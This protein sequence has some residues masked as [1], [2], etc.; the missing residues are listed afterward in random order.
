[1]FILWQITKGGQ[2]MLKDQQGRCWY[3]K[4]G[5][6][7]SDKLCDLLT[8][9]D[10][11]IVIYD[12]ETTGTTKDS[13]VV[14]FA[15][16][17]CEP[18]NGRY[19]I[20]K[21]MNQL[22]KPPIPM[23]AEASAVNHITDDM[24]K[25]APAEDFVVDKIDEIFKG[26]IV[27]GY[28]HVSFDNKML[29]NMY[30]R[31]RGIEFEPF[32]DISRNVDALIIA[33]SLVDRHEAPEQRFTLGSITDL[34]GIKPDDNEVLHDALADT[35][36]TMKLIWALARDYAGSEE[37][38]EYRDQKNRPP[39]S[40]VKMTRLTYSKIADYVV[41]NVNC[42]GMTGQFRYEIY[43]KRFVEING[44]IMSVGN[45]EQFIIDA[46]IAAGGNITKIKQE[47]KKK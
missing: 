42:Q 43:D 47:G 12:T 14:Q 31:T 18:V 29:N 7:M 34:Y 30:L 4:S 2:K 46:D 45:M 37:M 27:A 35:K 24:L 41:V 11:P 26:A 15:G 3:P 6:S 40:I 21:Q 32:K 20:T 38:N 10:T 16:I 25:D 8:R 1:M 28:N 36:V 39:I 5:Y 23:P 44:N 19:L 17:R 9:A 13:Y 22:I 33:R